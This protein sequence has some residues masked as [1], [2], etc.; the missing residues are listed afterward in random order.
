MSSILLE[1]Y[2]F[3]MRKRGVLQVA[4]QLNFWVEEDICNSLYLYVMSANGQVAW[5]AALQFIVYMV[6]VNAI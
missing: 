1:L 5:V 4:L 2:N 6:Q 3:I